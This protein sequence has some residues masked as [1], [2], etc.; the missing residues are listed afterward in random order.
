MAELVVLQVVQSESE[1]DMIR[2]LLKSEGIPSLVRQT[3]LGAGMTGGLPGAG[4][5]HEILVDEQNLSAARKVLEQQ[6]G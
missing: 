4:G 6:T 1:G 2:G 5:Q 3:S